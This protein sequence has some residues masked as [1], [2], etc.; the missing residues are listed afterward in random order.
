M[1]LRSRVATAAVT[2]SSLAL[3]V[4]VA[5]AGASMRHHSAHAAGTVTVQH[6]I[7]AGLQAA[8]DGLPL[9]GQA[10]ISGSLLGVDA[11][12]MGVDA[13]GQVL[14]IPLNLGIDLGAGVGGLL[15]L[16]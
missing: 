14:G 16:L 6:G 7:T 12:K 13:G 5:G 4:P 9:G 10:D 11:P 1:S 15:G 2:L 3:V 8:Q